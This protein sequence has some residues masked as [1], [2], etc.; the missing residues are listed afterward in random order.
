HV[1]GV[2]I[3]EGIR[4]AAAGIS[5][6]AQRNSDGIVEHHARLHQIR[7]LIERVGAHDQVR[8][9]VCQCRLVE[10]GRCCC[11]HW[12]VSSMSSLAPAGATHRITRICNTEEPLYW[13]LASLVSW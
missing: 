7:R 12:I 3:E 4:V 2:A 6:Q 13:P 9:A 8:R 5:E 11:C 10:Q 1:G